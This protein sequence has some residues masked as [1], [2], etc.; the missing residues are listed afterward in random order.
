MP[1]Y[2][3]LIFLLIFITGC[4]TQP[5]IGKKSFENEDKLILEALIYKENN[6]QKYL[7][8][9]N[10]L[11]KK[12]NKY[13]YLKEII[14]E[15]FLLSK[16]NLTIEYV[17]KFLK[18]Y[19][20]YSN[21]VIKY[22][23]LALI[24]LNKLNEALK[25]AKQF[26]KKNRNLELYQI[27]AFIY[28]KKHNYKEAIK[29]LKSAYSISHSPKILIQMGDIFFK[30]LKK[31]NEAISYYQTHI[32]LY[33]CDDIICIKLINIYKSL[34][35][36]D[37]LI[38]IYKKLYFSTN[39]LFYAKRVVFLYLEQ[40][41]YKK[42]IHFIKVNNLN[43]LLLPTYVII[44]QKTK[45]YKYAKKI[46]NLTKDKR[47]LFLYSV[48]KFENSKKSLLDVK[49]LIDNLYEVIKIYKKPEYLNYLGY[50][51][52]D[53]DINYTEGI[54]FI[55]EALK[56]E[57]DEAYLDS[58]AWGY[59]KLHKCKEAFKI[60]KK[61]KLKDKEILKHKKLIRRCYEHFRK[62]NK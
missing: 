52:I 39:N 21:E 50:I 19:P 49:E 47:Y 17:N 11:Y 58:L 24:K 31:P 23:V 62:N 30:N 53:Y 20:K 45:N 10:T 25:I 18:I 61:I 5:Q 36:Y 3:R 33:G 14:K 26:L 51:L 34:Y 9:L 2:Y 4:S 8:I 48:L 15:Y 35:D 54:E 32:R 43:N 40:N 16:Y 13:V 56:Q 60:I 59:Y 22:K 7:S 46:Y 37:N 42:A 6:P 12:T 27:I 57:N 29:Y 1:W 55:K 41:K 28:E 38:E 44:F